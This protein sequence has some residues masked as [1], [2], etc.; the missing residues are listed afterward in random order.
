MK[1]AAPHLQQQVWPFC[2]QVP[3]PLSGHHPQRRRRCSAD[4]GGGPQSEDQL[5]LRSLQGA[6]GERGGCSWFKGV[7]HL[8]GGDCRVWGQCGRHHGG[9]CGA[10]SRGQ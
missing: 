5:G 3:Q 4:C 1:K 8:Q 6:Q 2:R 10:Q 9:Q 7:R